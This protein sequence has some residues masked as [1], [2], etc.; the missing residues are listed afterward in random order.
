[1]GYIDIT[2]LEPTYWWYWL[3]WPQVAVGCHTLHGEDASKAEL[4]KLL[5]KKHVCAHGLFFAVVL[6]ATCLEY[7]WTLCLEG[8]IGHTAGKKAGMC[9]WSNIASGHAGYMLEVAL[10]KMPPTK[11]SPGHIAHKGTL[12]GYSSVVPTGHTGYELMCYW[13]V[14]A[15]GNAGSVLEEAFDNISPRKYWSYC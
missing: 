15:I 6:L 8:S 12:M 13:F 7:L 4:V 5:T 1:M 9:S 10:D 14:V 11:G 3:Y 2:L